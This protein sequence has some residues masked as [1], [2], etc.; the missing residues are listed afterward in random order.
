MN[1]WNQLYILKVFIRLWI[2]HTAKEISFKPD[3]LLERTDF[4]PY[5]KNHLESHF[6]YPLFTESILLSTK[7]VIG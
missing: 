1:K 6:F 3:N 5:K 2:W 7:K 4:F